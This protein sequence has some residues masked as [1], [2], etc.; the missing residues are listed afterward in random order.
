MDGYNCG[1]SLEEG[2]G[3]ACRV[4]KMLEDGLIRPEI[5][6]GQY[7]QPILKDREY[8]SHT[9]RSRANILLLILRTS[10]RKEPRIPPG[11]QAIPFGEVDPESSEVGFGIGV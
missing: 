10:Q 3:Q 2:E 7:G 9:I 4:D 11:L 5:K 1:P 8:L 6:V